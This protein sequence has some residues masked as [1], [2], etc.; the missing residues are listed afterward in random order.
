MPHA[1]RSGLLV[2][3]GLVVVGAGCISAP[4]APP[5]ASEQPPPA[6]ASKQGATPAAP[7]SRTPALPNLGELRARTDAFYGAEK[8][9]DWRTYYDLMDRSLRDAGSYEDFVADAYFEYQLLTWR[10]VSIAPA[11]TQNRPADVTVEAKVAMDVKV[12]HP[13]KSPESVADQ[14]DYWVY[15]DGHWYWIWR[16]WPGE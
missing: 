14:T 8:T 7:E 5:A 13:G 6:A 12:Q 15:R 16:G 4:Q 1:G 3:I 9:R 10:I 11:Q 2:C